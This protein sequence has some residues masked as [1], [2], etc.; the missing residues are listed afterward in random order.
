MLVNG[1]SY[2]PSSGVS[3]AESAPISRNLTNPSPSPPLLQPV[4]QSAFS[5][6]AVNWSR[7]GMA[8]ASKVG[9]SGPNLLRLPTLPTLCFIQIQTRVRELPRIFQRRIKREKA[10]GTIAQ[11][12]SAIS[13]TNTTARY[14]NWQSRGTR[15]YPASRR[16]TVSVKFCHQP[17][18]CANLI[19]QTRA[20]SSTCLYVV[21]LINQ[22]IRVI[23]DPVSI[24]A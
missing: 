20:T 22:A 9:V 4:L 23:S 14:Q 15:N 24:A 6:L 16:G 7:I 11:H 2:S 12:D 3:M 13:K 17:H 8:V 1:D 18:P 19:S 10:S 5:T 21:Q